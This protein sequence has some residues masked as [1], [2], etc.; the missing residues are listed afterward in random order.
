MEVLP[1][2]AARR[3]HGTHPESSGMEEELP[4]DGATRAGGTGVDLETQ[5]LPRPH[6]NE[7]RQY[8]DQY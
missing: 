7:T 6:R 1:R 4:G 2:L 3:R 5:E 8:G